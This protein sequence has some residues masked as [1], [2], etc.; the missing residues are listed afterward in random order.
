MSLSD[1]HGYWGDLLT[2]EH[3][4][5]QLKTIRIHLFLFTGKY[6]GVKAGET[7]THRHDNER[8]GALFYIDADTAIPSHIWGNL[9][10]SRRSE[11]C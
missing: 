7:D 2:K 9:A 4:I 10:G 6:P 3:F 5:V 11:N 1:A 8:L